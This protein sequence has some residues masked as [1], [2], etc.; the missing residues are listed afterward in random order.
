MKSKSFSVA[1]LT[2]ALLGSSL[3]FTAPNA[4]AALPLAVE[5]QKLPS[6]AP[7]LERVTPAVVSISVAGT[8]V[9]RQRVP[10]AFRFFFGP[11][12][13]REQLREQPFQGLGSGVIID[14]REGYVVT[15]AH[16]VDDADKIEVTLSDG[17]TFEAK[18]IGADEGADIALL[19]IEAK[20]L[21]A[22]SKADSDEVRVGDFAVAI[23]NPLGL[24]QTVT[25]GIVSALGRSGLNVENFEDFIQTD[26]AINRGNS[27]G[28][29][30]NLKGELIGINTAIIGPNGGNIGIGFAIPANMMSNLV[31]QIIDHGEVRRGYLGITGD[32]L[33]SELAETMGFDSNQGAFVAQVMEDSAAEA[34]GIKAGDIITHVNGKRIKSFLELR[35]KVATL[36]EGAKL[37]IGLFRDGDQETVT[38]TLKGRADVARTAEGLHPKLEGAVLESAKRREDGA[39][40]V[41]VVNVAPR[42]PAAISGLE[43]GD[44][45]LAVNR[46]R[47]EDLGELEDVLDDADGVLALN[48]KRGRHTL[49]LVIR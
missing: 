7:M 3:L 17:R 40:G 44:I 26:A 14:A 8:H 20:D 16:V 43:E 27:G 24:G 6:L 35:A 13:P 19:Q 45:I 37:K 41:K 48:I 29:L 21:T 4:S 38:V 34:A 31:E 28:A 15:N 32:V 1:A 2:A 47:V 39:E 23:G 42:S 49:F 25:S 18:K 30:V 12:V 10:D 5:G 36:G 33:T 46:K 9:Q 22:I 11:N